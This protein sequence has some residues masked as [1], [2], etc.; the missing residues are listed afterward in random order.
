MKKYTLGLILFALFAV[1]VVIF[2]INGF[3]PIESLMG[4]PKLEG[5][6][7]AIQLA[8]ED[9]VEKGYKLKSPIGGDYRSAYIFKDLDSDGQDE[10]IVFYSTEAAVDIIR[11]NVLK[12]ID[13]EWKSVADYE[14]SHSEIHR[15]KFSDLNNDKKKEII[16]GWSVYQNEL[17]RK[18]NVYKIFDTDEIRIANIF[19]ASYSEFDVMDVNGDSRQDILIFDADKRTESSTYNLFMVNYFD[20]KFQLAEAYQLDSSIT[21]IKSIKYDF[22]SHIDARRI[23]VDGYKTDSSL[24]TD[25]IY[26]DRERNCFERL[27]VDDITVPSVSSRN[28][29]VF[30]D[31]INSDGLIEIPVVKAMPKSRVI[32]EGSTQ[33]QG[34]SIIEWIRFEDDEIKSICHRIINSKSNYEIQIPT[35]LVSKV[36][37]SNNHKNNIITF[38]ELIDEKNGEYSTGELLFSL[39]YLDSHSD[40]R[41]PSEYRFLKETARGEIYYRIHHTANEYDIDKTALSKMIIK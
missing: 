29:N 33:P 36:T 11:M 9:S 15:V 12:K 31:D 37:V 16:V 4:P 21:S 30:C 20:N 18:L 5:E 41:I 10:V 23:F 1:P 17:S 6:N 19:D 2:C 8:F 28:I 26:F 22:D 7:L 32:I 24:I 3:K 34:Q 25:C 39:Y 27:S 14:S 40:I 35:D 38:Y 13:G